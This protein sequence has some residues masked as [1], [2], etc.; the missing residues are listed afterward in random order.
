MRLDAR[1]DGMSALTVLW[2]TPVARA[3]YEALTAYAKACEFDEEGNRDPRPTSSG[4]PTAWPTSSCARTPI[5]PGADRPHPDRRRGHP[6][7]PRTGRRRP[8]R[9]RRRPGAAALVREL[10]YTLGLL[11]APARQP[12]ITSTGPHPATTAGVDGGEAD[13]SRPS[14]RATYAPDREARVGLAALRAEELAAAEE[15]LTTYDDRG[16]ERRT[17]GG[18]RSPACWTPG[19]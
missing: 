19:G 18:R 1:D 13:V 6:H 3:C 2:A 17:G 8:G 9:G 16:R 10:A 14:A 7:R 12:D 15:L 11:P 4:C 5:T